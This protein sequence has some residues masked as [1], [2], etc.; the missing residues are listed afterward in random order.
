VHFQFSTVNLKVGV[1]TDQF[2]L[3]AWTPNPSHVAEAVLMPRI[4]GFGIAG[5]KGG[6]DEGRFVM[7]LFPGE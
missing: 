3:T 7:H 6:H 4:P 2:S 1:N 5:K